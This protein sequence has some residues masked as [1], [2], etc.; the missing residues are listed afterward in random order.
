MRRPRELRSLRLTVAIADAAVIA[1][2]F[3]VVFV[4]YPQIRDTDPHTFGV[5][6]MLEIGVYVV[7]WLA[8]LAAYRL[9]DPEYILDG[10]EQYSRLM[11]ASTIG[12]LFLVG[13]VALVGGSTLIG[14][15][16]LL[17]SWFLSLAA[18]GLSRFLI[19]RI[20]R[21]LRLRG[22]FQARMLIV[23][24][25]EDGLAI[26]EQLTTHAPGAA[27]VVGFLDEYHPLGTRIGDIPVLGEPLALARHARQTSATDAIIVPQ[28]ISWESLQALL[29]GG[30]EAWG[31][32]RLWLAP[33]FRDLFTTGMEVH[34][35]GTMPLLAVAAPRIA[36][37]E[38]ALKRGLD[39]ALALAV[40]PF[41][42]VVC[43]PIALWLAFVR[44]VSPLAQREVIGRN[45][46]HFHLI[47]FPED[48][49][50]QRWHLWRLPALLNVLRGELSLVGPR[51]IDWRL[52]ARYQQWQ[53]MLTSLRP[54]L[55]GP[56]WLLS[57]SRRLSV[58]A[59]VGADLA[60]IRGYSIWSDVRILALTARRLLARRAALARSAGAARAETP[61]TES[62]ATEPLASGVRAV[63]SLSSETSISGSA[64]PRAT[65]ATPGGSR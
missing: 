50:L 24:A 43:V 11:Q 26:A 65:T 25:G 38:A 8:L 36:G 14:R 27:V 33:A 32:Q 34:Q 57:G 2:A 28:V 51:P 30:A 62:F 52:H 23:G 16:W 1:L 63:E 60:Y 37:L 45:R 18:L 64:A 4:L 35:R 13:V 46:R 31:V 5:R 55:T 56:W 61:I 3:A 15:S 9:Y 19:R 48:P 10:S 29:Q 42:L 17:A 6:R 54:G 41:A 22:L 58:A 49:Q 40:L 44:H 59:E 39:L 7:G 21:R 12:L 53:V 47:T 20:V